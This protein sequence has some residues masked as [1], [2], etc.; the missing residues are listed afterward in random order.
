MIKNKRGSH[1][2]FIISFVLFVSFLIFFIGI[3]KPFEKTETGKGTLLKHLENEIIKE[4]SDEVLVV[5]ALEDTSSDCSDSEINNLDITNY[6]SQ[7]KGNLLKIYSSDEFPTNNFPCTTAPPGYK[8]GLVRNEIY[9]IQSKF[10]E[11]NNSYNDNYETL[12]TNF[13]IPEIN[14]FEFSFLNINKEVIIETSSK[15]TPPTEVLAELV[16]ITYLDYSDED[17]AE[18]K[19]GYI[20]VVLW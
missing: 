16:P 13:G 20:K 1:I 7:Q 11:L 9:A 6:I 19:N 14:D 10:S 12:K 5:S 3:I 18:I 2:S 4:V 17:N 15:E 8:I